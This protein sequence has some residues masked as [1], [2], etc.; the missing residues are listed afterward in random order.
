MKQTHG[1]LIIHGFAA[2]LDSVRDLQAP[3]ERLHLTVRMP[4][5]RGHGA[6]TPD[7]L[8]GV[9][10]R[11]WVSDS[12]ASLRALLKDVDNAIVIGHGMGGMLALILAA[13]N[14]E[15]IDSLVLAAASIK[16]PK[17]M[18]TRMRVQ[19]LSPLVQRTFPRW[20]L[21]PVYTDKELRKS[22]TNYH[23]APMDA[24][25]SFIELT[26]VTRGRLDEVTVP[27]LII[28]SRKDRTISDDCPEIIRTGISTPAKLKR[29]KWF[30]Q[31]EH[32]LIPRL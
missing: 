13:N 1:I 29:I 9:T 3:L 12:E 17:P 4:V 27:T 14:H 19:V 6:E 28:Q 26:E 2:S 11:D 7:A 15:G 25:R 31:S 8:R 18:V 24:I 22:D 20:G 16:L 5:L 23:W 32:E 10:W 30:E 21:P